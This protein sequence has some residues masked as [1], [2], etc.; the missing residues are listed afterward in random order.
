VDW[1]RIAESH[2][3]F[4]A[5]SQ[6]PAVHQLTGHLGF[7]YTTAQL[8]AVVVELMTRAAYPNPQDQRA[9]QERSQPNLTGIRNDAMRYLLK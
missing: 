6:L 9:L 1:A 5:M 2:K 4:V 8:A 7:S 3:D